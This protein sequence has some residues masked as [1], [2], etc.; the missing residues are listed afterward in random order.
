MNMIVRFQGSGMDRMSD[1]ST[2]RL[3]NVRFQ[4]RDGRISMQTHWR[5]EEM[6]KMFILKEK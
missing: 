3:P 5:L 4:T 1:D 2:K 6:P